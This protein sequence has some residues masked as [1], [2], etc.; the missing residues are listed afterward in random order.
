MKGRKRTPTQIKLVRGNP[1]KRKINKNEP[2]GQPIYPDPSKDLKYAETKALWKKYA[3]VAFRMGVLTENSE[4]TWSVTWEAYDDYL[5]AREDVYK[6]GITLET[7]GANNSVVQKANPAI[8]MMENAWRRHVHGL[9]L[10]GF[11]PMDQG[12]VTVDK[13][14]EEEDPLLAWELHRRGK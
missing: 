8:K 11:N 9:S 6:N 5:K 1:G 7:T 3:P 10:F 4:H 12:K 13:P 14:E 2:K